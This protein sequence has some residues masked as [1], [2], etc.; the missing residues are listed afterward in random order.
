MYAVAEATSWSS[1]CSP[2]AQ[3]NALNCDIELLTEGKERQK[4]LK[5]LRDSVVE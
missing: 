5:L 1:K 3:Y 2:E 4:I